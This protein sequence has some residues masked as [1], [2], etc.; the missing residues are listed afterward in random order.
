MIRTAK[1]GQHELLKQLEA[2]QL[3]RAKANNA[4]VR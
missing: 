4:G 3:K 1:Q 2:G